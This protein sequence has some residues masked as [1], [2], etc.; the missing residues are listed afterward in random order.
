MPIPFYD[1]SA[2]CKKPARHLNPEKLRIANEQFDELIKDGF[3]E[4]APR[5][6]PFAS[7]IVLILY[8]DGKR[9]RLTN[10]YSGSPGINSLTK[11]LQAALPRITDVSM[12]LSKAR[13]IAT[14]DLPKDFWQLKLREQDWMKTTLAIP[15]RK[16]YFKRAAFGLK[17]VPVFFQN[18]MNKIL[19]MEN[20]FIYLDDVIVTA[21]SPESFL[22]TLQEIFFRAKTHRLC[23]GLKKCSFISNDS[24]N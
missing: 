24:P 22:K 23:F 17:N 12:F 21:N 8:P 14:L 7:P 20:V 5:D 6:C 13:F 4:E 3:A 16:I 1:K 9:P 2:S 19:K 10:D 15:G 18:V 11:P